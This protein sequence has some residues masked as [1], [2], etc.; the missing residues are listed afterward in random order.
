MAH[1][2]KSPSYEGNAA[3][4]SLP[5]S[6]KQKNRNNYTKRKQAKTSAKLEVTNKSNIY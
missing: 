3:G 6:T 2:L 4:R 1:A 5:L